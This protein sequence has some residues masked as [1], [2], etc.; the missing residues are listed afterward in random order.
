M[1][2]SKIPLVDVALCM[3]SLASIP[4]EDRTT[5]QIHLAFPEATVGEGDGIQ[6]HKHM[7]KGDL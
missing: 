4:P 2:G 6:L 1:L 3:V 7:C 5:H